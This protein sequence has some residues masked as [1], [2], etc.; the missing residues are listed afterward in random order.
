MDAWDDEAAEQEKRHQVNASAPSNVHYLH[1]NFLFL[2]AT[3]A[4]SF[5]LS[6]SLPFLVSSVPS[7]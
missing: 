2:L 5:F 6:P 3:S 1:W 7:I 4:P